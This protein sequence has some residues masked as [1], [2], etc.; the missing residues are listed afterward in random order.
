M[1]R[2]LIQS[3]GLSPESLG[4]FAPESP[5]KR[6]SFDP[7]GLQKLFGQRG[8]LLSGSESLIVANCLPF[9]YQNLYIQAFGSLNFSN[10]GP[11]FGQAELAAYLR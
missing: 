6:W 2:R 7:N 8:S 11:D 10:R 1:A 9:L 5:L 3:F 4:I